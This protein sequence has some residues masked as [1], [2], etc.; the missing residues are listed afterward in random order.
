MLHVYCPDCDRDVN[1]N[2]HPSE[3]YAYYC[4]ITH[5]VFQLEQGIWTEQHDES[6]DGYPHHGS[7]VRPDECNCVE[8]AEDDEEKNFASVPSEVSDMWLEARS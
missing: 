5:T 1:L 7:P 6:I 3:G 4:P 8:C 2:V